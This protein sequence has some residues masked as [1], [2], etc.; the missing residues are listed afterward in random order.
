MIRRA[1]MYKITNTLNNL[2]YIG[3]TYNPK[4]RFASHTWDIKDR[5]KRRQLLKNAMF[6]HGKENF[7]MQILCIGGLKYCHELEKKAIAV[8][9]TLEPNGYNVT[10]GGLGSVGVIGEK[11]GTWGRVGEAHPNFGKVGYRTGMPHSEETKAKMKAS[12][13]GKVVSLEAKENIRRAVLNRSPE[14]KLKIA[15]AMRAG[16]EKKRSLKCHEDI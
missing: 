5:S 1:Y 11:S 13:T 3:V 2:V 16:L 10:A 12:H 9:N 6:E 8:Y 15:E 14:I 4:R 7:S